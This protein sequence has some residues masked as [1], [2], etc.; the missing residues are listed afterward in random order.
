MPIKKLCRFNEMVEES[1]LSRNGFVM[2]CVFGRNRHNPAVLKHLAELLVIAAEIKTELKSKD[3]LDE[4]VLREL[5]LIRT[6]LMS[7]MGRRS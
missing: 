3:C 7:L 4:E 6:A 1:G 2:N 5:I